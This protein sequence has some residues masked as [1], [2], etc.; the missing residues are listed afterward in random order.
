L[1]DT[2]SDGQICV[3][4][5]R[6]AWARLKVYEPGGGDFITR[7]ALKPHATI[8]L[9]HGNRAEQAIARANYNPIARP[10][11]KG[12][13]W[14]RRMDRNNDGDVSRSEFLGRPE[15][16]DKLDTDHDGLISVEEAEAADKRF[17]NEKPVKK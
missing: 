7:A 5:M 6:N 4:E 14:F 9:V 12:P 1:I 3:R 13:L 17:R 2:N 10:T 16:F 8:R 11:N 15:E